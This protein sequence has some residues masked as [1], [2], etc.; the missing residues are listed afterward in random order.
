M[1]YLH[2]LRKIIYKPG[3][4][5]MHS[6]DAF[7]GGRIKL[8]QKINGLRATSDSVLVA[9]AVQAK[10]NET[11]LD[12][13]AGNGVIGLCI[14]A[15]VPIKLTALEIQED[16]VSL[17][18]ENALLN[19]KKITVIRNDIF[20]SEDPLKGQLFNHVV[21]NPPFYD[22]TGDSR[23]DAEQ[24]LAY[25]ANFDLK[26]WLDYCLK[27]L[28]AKGS[29]TMIHRPECLPVILP[30]LAK[31]LGNIQI[32]PI[33]AKTNTG[34]KRVII[35]G[36]L[37]SARPLSLCPPIVMHTQAEKPSHRANSILRSGHSI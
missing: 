7:L 29:F 3:D 8:K 17:I 18:Q 4:F 25:T 9:A 14:S 26:I 34:A 20:Q 30:V 35:R 33:Q 22:T 21:T 5:N 2:I 31:K 23:K 27:H 6:T 24:A 28:R 12:V 16:L 19:D 1:V 13:G 11:I 36:I 10:P 15:R 32:I 37:G